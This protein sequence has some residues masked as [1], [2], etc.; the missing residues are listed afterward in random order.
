MHNVIYSM[1]INMMYS[2]LQD[3]LLRNNSIQSSRVMCSSSSSGLQPGVGVP[4]PQRCKKIVSERNIGNSWNLN[5]L[6]SS[7]SRR[8]VLRLRCW[9]VKTSSVISKFKRK[10]VWGYANQKRLS[11]TCLEEISRYSC[12]L[13]QYQWHYIA[14]QPFTGVGQGCDPSDL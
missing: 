14:F 4:P 2:Y 11:T 7:H 1:N 10:Y 5:Q 8:F 12:P 3:S 9:H 13:H 6:W